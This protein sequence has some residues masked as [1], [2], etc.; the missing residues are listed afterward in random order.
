MYR[1]LEGGEKMVDYLIV[2]YGSLGSKICQSLKKKGERILVLESYNENYNKAIE[3]G[4]EA[5][6]ADARDPTLLRRVG[7]DKVKVVIITPSD[8]NVIRDV[9]ES[10]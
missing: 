9:I 3:D 5:R 10:V 2:G 4:M 7:G 8:P 1:P 6:L